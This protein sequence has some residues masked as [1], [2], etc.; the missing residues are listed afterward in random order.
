MYIT[1][2]YN[3]Y[4]KDYAKEIYNTCTISLNSI[5]YITKR[6]PPTKCQFSEK[7]VIWDINRINQYTFKI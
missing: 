4:T 6:A 7:C 1:A 3:K 2:D 5:M